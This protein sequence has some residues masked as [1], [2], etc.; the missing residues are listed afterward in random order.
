MSGN[1]NAVMPAIS[2]DSVASVTPISVWS[3]ESRVLMDAENILG[4]RMYL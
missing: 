3:S 2:R 4:S 1:V